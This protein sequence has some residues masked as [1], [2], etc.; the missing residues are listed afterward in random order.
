MKTKPRK[1]FIA[2]VIL[3]AT[4]SLAFAD[5]AATV[6]P[7]A[8]DSGYPTA[9]G[10]QSIGWRFFVDEEMTITHLGLYDD[11]D[12]GLAGTHTMGIWR[13]NKDGGLDLMRQ[14]DIGPGGTTEDHHVY[15][16][17]EDLTL[18]PDPIPGTQGLERWLVGVWS[19]AAS[20]G[21]TIRPRSAATILA[22]SA[23]FITIQNY[24]WKGTTVFDAPWGNNSDYDYFGVNFKYTAVDTTPP[25]LTCPG[26]VTITAMEPE[27]V[28][29][30]DERI[31]TWLDGASATDD[32]DPEPTISNDAPLLFEPGDTV[33]TFVAEDAAGNI[34]TCQSTVTVV[35]AADAELKII[36]RIINRDGFLQKVLAALRLPEGVTRDDVDMSAPVLLYPGDSDVGI[37]ACHVWVVQWYWCG[38]IRTKVFAYFDKDAIME[39]V[40]EDGYV[41]MAVIGRLVDGQYF[42]GDC[43]V[44]VISWQWGH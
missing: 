30:D 5:V 20:D 44:K 22:E 40:P 26:D 42:Y 15:V 12:D 2:F 38:Q 27:G 18:V 11:G 16:D 13:V 39:A 7:G 8:I 37:E 28:W 3:A 10:N 17:I 35:E 1:A 24:T 43:T 41:D 23:G 14:V 32:S 34:S 33:V 4:A 29:V 6:D 36:P 9:T 19:G 21:L 25:E 31:Q